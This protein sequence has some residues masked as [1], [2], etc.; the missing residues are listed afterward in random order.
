[1]WYP[2]KGVDTLGECLYNAVVRALDQALADGQ[3]WNRNPNLT[4]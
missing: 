2:A 1:M 4:C 3:K